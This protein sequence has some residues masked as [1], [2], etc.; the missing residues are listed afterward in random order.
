ML[1]DIIM[2]DF[3][4]LVGFIV[5]TNNVN[6]KVKIWIS[7]I[8]SVPFSS[9][10]HIPFLKGTTPNTLFWSFLCNYANKYH[11]EKGLVRMDNQRQCFLLVKRQRNR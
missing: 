8:H 3:F 4:S 6:I 7:E 9:K 2:N 5:H 1:I 10:S 11:A